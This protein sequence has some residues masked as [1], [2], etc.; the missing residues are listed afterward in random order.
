[1]EAYLQ[2]QEWIKFYAGLCCGSSEK[3]KPVVYIYL[4]S[5]IKEAENTPDLLLSE[6]ETQESWRCTS[7]WFWRLGNRGAAG[8]KSTADQGP[9]PAV[10]QKQWILLSSSFLFYSGP[11]WVKWGP[12]TLGRAVWIQPVCWFKRH[13]L[14]ETPS[15]TYP[16][17][18]LSQMS[19]HPL[20]HSNWHIKLIRP[21]G[22]CLPS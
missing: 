17:I 3:K 1:M 9:A 10:R 18:K 19:G 14:L 15:Q 11:Q 12:P 2:L 5:V 22:Y 21:K 7:V 13:S 6:L 20:I 8:V 4:S 16:K